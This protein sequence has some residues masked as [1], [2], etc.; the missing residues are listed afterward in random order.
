MIDRGLLTPDDD[1]SHWL[2]ARFTD[3]GIAALRRIDGDKRVLSPE[4][5]PTAPSQAWSGAP[6]GR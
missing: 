2:T 5:I 3:M 1:G 4:K 6:G